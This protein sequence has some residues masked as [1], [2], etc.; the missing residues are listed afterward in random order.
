MTTKLA[1]FGGGRRAVVRNAHRW[2]IRAGLPVPEEAG[3]TNGLRL[4]GGI[5]LEKIILRLQLKVCDG[6]EGPIPVEGARFFVVCFTLHV[7]E[8]I[9]VVRKSGFAP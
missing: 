3:P 4:R 1:R 9:L 5:Q 2:A 7:G 6:D 8:G